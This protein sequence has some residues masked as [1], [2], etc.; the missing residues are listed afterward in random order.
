VQRLYQAALFFIL[1][2][3]VG[4]RT[5]RYSNAY[6]HLSC[7]STECHLKL[8]STGWKRPVSLTVAR[9]QIISAMAVKTQ[10]DGTFVT[11]QNVQIDDYSR[12]VD[13]KK[14]KKKTS[15]YKGPGD[16]GYYITYAI[17][18]RDKWKVD[19]DE[20]IEVNEDAIVAS[21]DPIRA[22]LQESTDKG[23]FRLIPRQHR[24]VQ[25]RRR[26][27]SM[28]QKFQGYIRRRRQRLILKENAAPSWQGIVM[29]VLGVVGL[30]MALLL[31]Q[32]WAEE[33]EMTAIRK[34]AQLRQ[35]Q[36]YANMDRK[37]RVESYH[38]SGSA[39]GPGIRSQQQAPQYGRSRKRI[40]SSWNQ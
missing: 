8:Q 23:D 5:I 21:L 31:G 2:T 22:F 11:D 40:T 14:K 1:L 17:T 7:H 15:A 19:E 30:L 20:N 18:L 12:V 10:K 33:D 32:L 34:N 29:V 9:E 6:I 35:R 24:I 39:G 38:R 13:K 28:T 37:D 16:D 4:Y 25:S 26:V 27:R 36:K 3:Y